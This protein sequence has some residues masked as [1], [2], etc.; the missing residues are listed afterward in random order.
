MRQF[1]AMGGY[2]QWVWTAFG[3]ALVVLTG[4]V[5][6]ARRRYR[7]TLQR[8]RVRMERTGAQRS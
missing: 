4:N 7:T 5:V 3:L 8:L 1:L 2:A 6:G